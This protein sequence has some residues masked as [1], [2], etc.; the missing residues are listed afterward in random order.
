MCAARCWLWL[1]NGQCTGCPMKAN[2]W[3]FFYFS[4]YLQPQ[5]FSYPVLLQ[6]TPWNYPWPCMLVTT[7]ICVVY[8]Q[9]PYVVLAI[10][11]TLCGSSLYLK[12]PDPLWLRSIRPTTQLLKNCSLNHS[13]TGSRCN[14]TVETGPVSTVPVYVV[15]HQTRDVSGHSLFSWPTCMLVFST[16]LSA[17]ILWHWSA[18]C[19]CT[20]S[21]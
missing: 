11:F 16:S 21:S 19:T 20:P 4:P 8:R 12:K 5:T 9:W 10:R 6:V 15:Y 1:N 13:F 18:E 2:G 14:V 17:P 7:R 3:Y